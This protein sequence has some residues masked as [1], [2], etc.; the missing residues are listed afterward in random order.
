MRFLLLAVVCCSSCAAPEAK[1]KQAVDGYCVKV[2]HHPWPP[3]I[4]KQ[5]SEEW[6]KVHPTHSVFGEWRMRVVTVIVFEGEPL[7]LEDKLKF[8][9]RVRELDKPLTK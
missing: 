7:T 4:G 6:T 2:E 5:I 3:D 8:E 1:P 9:A